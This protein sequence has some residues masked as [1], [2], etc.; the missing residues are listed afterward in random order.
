MS[1]SIDDISRAIAA[2]SPK[3]TCGADLNGKVEHYDHEHG[4]AVSD[5]PTR[6][7]LYVVC[8]KC[9]FQW[10]IDRGPFGIP[11]E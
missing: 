1:E 11:R 9:G 5:Y 3:C 6:Q 10:A 2:K 8:R 4:W 7:W